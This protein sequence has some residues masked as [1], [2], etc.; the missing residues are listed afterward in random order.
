MANDLVVLEKQ[1]EPLMPAL[2]QALA[3]T[4]PVERLMRTVMI[5]C[6]RMPRLLECDRQSLFN[7]AMTFAVLGLEVDGVS[8]QGYLIPFAGKVQPVIGYKGYN[9]LAA[10]AGITID[11]AVVREGDEFEYEEGTTPFVRH[12]KKLGAEHGRR[13][14]AAWA[15]ASAKDRPPVIKVLSIDELEAVRAK[16]PGAK[17]SDSP[18]NDP[19]IG[20][21]AMYEKTV[22]R[23]L[24]R[25]MPLNVMQL[26]SRLDEAFDEQGKPGFI[27][28]DKTLM[29]DG[30]IADRS[31]TNGPSARELIDGR[32]SPAASGRAEASERQ[33]AGSD[34]SGADGGEDPVEQ[35]SRDLAMSASNGMAALQAEWKT[36]HTTYQKQLKQKLDEKWKPIA[37]KADEQNARRA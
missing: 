26:A 24:A 9:T 7:A 33:G 1:F 25:S 4:M 22:K 10:R 28:P 14:V 17:K 13:I 3:Q 32:T 27:A 29:I 19:K 6:Q 8:G 15:V 16:S 5:S 35:I 36:V 18:W 37:E 23:R 12:K 11:G 20:L 21:I 2:Q 34:V 31:Q 30:V